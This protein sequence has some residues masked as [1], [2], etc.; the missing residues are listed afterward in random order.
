MNLAKVTCIISVKVLRYGLCGCVAACYIKSMVVCVCAV[1]SFTLHSTQHTL[2][3]ASVGE[4][5]LTQASGSSKQ[6]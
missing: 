1:L 4:L 3:T 6:A 5:Q 2:A